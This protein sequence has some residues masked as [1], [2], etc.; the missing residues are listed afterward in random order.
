VLQINNL[1]YILSGENHDY[2]ETER[3]DERAMGSTLFALLPAME[4]GILGAFEAGADVAVAQTAIDPWFRPTFLT[5]S[6]LFALGA[7][8]FA[9]AIARSGVMSPRLTWLVVAALVVMAIGRVVPLGVV[10]FYVGPAAGIVA[11]WPLAYQ[12]WKHPAPR[13]AGLQ[14]PMPAT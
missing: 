4:I 1:R 10:Q 12:M 5:G 8:G 7:L 9:R 2:S 6:I 3:D 13:V 14:Q 11:L